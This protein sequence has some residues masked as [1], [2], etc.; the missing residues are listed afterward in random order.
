M[1]RKNDRSS[2]SLWELRM[3]L[4]GD[5]IITLIILTLPL[6]IPPFKLYRKVTGSISKKTTIL[7]A[8]SVL[9]DGRKVE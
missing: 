3:G 6:I 7:I 4:K 8:G 9:E 5:I 1:E 2:S